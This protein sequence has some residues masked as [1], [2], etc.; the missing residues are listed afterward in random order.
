MKKIILIGFGI[1]CL[2]IPRAFASGVFFADNTGPASN[3]R[4]V[5]A[6]QTATR[7]T[8]TTTLNR[9]MVVVNDDAENSVFY[10]GSDCSYVLGQKIDPGDKVTFQGVTAGFNFYVCTA[11][12]SAEVRI[13]EHS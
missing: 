10:G 1:A 9:T 11:S 8:M 3:G 4:V 7:V 2:A 12:G 5:L 13:A 6:T